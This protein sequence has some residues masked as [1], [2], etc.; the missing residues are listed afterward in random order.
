MTPRFLIDKSQAPLDVLRNIAQSRM[1]T[2]TRPGGLL[3][4]S[5]PNGLALSSRLH[6]PLAAKMSPSVYIYPQVARNF[7][8]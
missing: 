1:A 4:A 7:Y 5:G 6:S 3:S 8:L 2:Y